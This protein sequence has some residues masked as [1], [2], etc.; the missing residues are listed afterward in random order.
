MRIFFGDFRYFKLKYRLR[1]ITKTRKLKGEKIECYFY[2]FTFPCFFFYVFIVYL[3]AV[4]KKMDFNSD[5]LELLSLMENSMRLRLIH[6]FFIEMNT[7]IFFS[8]LFYLQYKTFGG[9]FANHLV[10]IFNKCFI[11]MS[12]HWCYT[13]N[14][15]FIQK[16]NLFFCFLFYVLFLPSLCPFLLN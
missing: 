2:L 13:L 11:Q 5:E 8:Q 16:Q 1:I 6:S 9:S 14:G 15:Y 3:K 12:Q 10:S 4:K 7:S